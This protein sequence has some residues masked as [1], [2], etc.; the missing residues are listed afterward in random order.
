MAEMSLMAG[1]QEFF[2]IVFGSC[3]IGIQDHIYNLSL[4]V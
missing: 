1:I 3:F 2:S 4:Q